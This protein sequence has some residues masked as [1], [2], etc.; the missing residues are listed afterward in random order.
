MYF[1]ARDIGVLDI[2]DNAWR[3]D[4]QVRAGVLSDACAALLHGPGDDPPPDE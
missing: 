1:E 3:D 2:I 4:V